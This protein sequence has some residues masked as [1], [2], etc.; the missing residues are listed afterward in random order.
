[1]KKNI[2]SLL[3]IGFIAMVSMS[4]QPSANGS[5][6]SGSSLSIIK[7]DVL[8]GH[9]DRV[10]GVTFGLRGFKPGENEIIS[11]KVFDTAG[12][13][14]GEIIEFESEDS[15]GDHGAYWFEVEFE[16]LRVP[17]T[18]YIVVRVSLGSASGTVTV[19]GGS[20]FSMFALAP[21]PTPTDP[22]ETTLIVR[23]P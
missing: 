18:F 9:H 23:Y 4:F 19:S 17:A 8:Y 21:P 13:F 5:D 10:E 20:T 16:K 6:S 7:G 12:I 3:F 14:I 11:V 2:V 15:R 22:D 1:M